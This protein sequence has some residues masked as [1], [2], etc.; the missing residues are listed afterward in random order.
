MTARIGDGLSTYRD[1]VISRV[2]QTASRLGAA[3]GMR[4]K[5]WVERLL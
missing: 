1:G 2:N 3:P 5:T 4:A